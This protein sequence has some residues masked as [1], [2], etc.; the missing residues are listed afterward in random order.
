MSSDNPNS[1]G[2]ASA[3]VTQRYHGVSRFSKSIEICRAVPSGVVAHRGD[4]SGM[5]VVGTYI[6]YVDH[7]FNVRVERAVTCTATTQNESKYFELR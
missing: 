5:P 1:D 3:G 7:C 6:Q 2:F 4:P